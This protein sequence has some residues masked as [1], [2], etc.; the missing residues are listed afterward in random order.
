MNARQISVTLIALLFAFGVIA[1]HHRQV[2]A[3]VIHI[4]DEY[5]NVS[6]DAGIDAL[7]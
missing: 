7:R 4:S 1:K 3:E 2:T 6:I 5:G